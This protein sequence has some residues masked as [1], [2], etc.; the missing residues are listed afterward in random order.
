MQGKL[1]I[2]VNAH[3]EICGFHK[4]GGASIEPDVM[5]K[6]TKVSCPHGGFRTP[7]SL[8]LVTLRFFLILSKLATK[9]ALEV[10]EL[11]GKAFYDATVRVPAAGAMEEVPVVQE[12]MIS[13]GNMK[14]VSPTNAEGKPMQQQQPPPPREDAVMNEV[15]PP[16]PPPLTSLQSSN[17]STT[18]TVT[19][20]VRLSL[21]KASRNM[22]PTCVPTSTLIPLPNRLLT[23]PLMYCFDKDVKT[24][25]QTADKKPTPKHKHA[26]SDEDDEDEDDDDDDDLMNAV[27]SRPR[28]GGGRKS[29]PRLK[30]S[31][32][33]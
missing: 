27:I 3:G 28:G 26:D 19:Q 14:I 21:F 31:T 24:A 33:Q 16:P 10:T 13:L 1:T 9:R 15:N 4:A 17:T 22:S 2:I 32:R 6:C 29:K 12:P 18:T 7:S 23:N 30:T 20:M 25:S 5:M 11:L 8:P